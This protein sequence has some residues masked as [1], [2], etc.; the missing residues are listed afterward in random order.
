MRWWWVSSVR[1]FCIIICAL[2][3]LACGGANED[4]S[5][6]ST[7]SSCKII[8]SEALFA[9]DRNNDLKQCWNAIGD[10]YESKSDALQWCERQV[11]AYIA[12]RYIIGHTVAYAVESTY[13][14]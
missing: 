7:Y 1:T 9:N 13:C 11:N 10:G 8:S 4:G 5:S 14:K 12:N 6:K 2:T 3:M